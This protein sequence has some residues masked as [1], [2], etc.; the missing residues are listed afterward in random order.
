MIISADEIK[1]SFPEYSPERVEELHA[2]SAKQADKEFDTSLKVSLFKTVALMSGGTASG[3]TEFLVTHLE[4][5]P[6][7]VLDGTLPTPEGAKIKIKKILKARKVPVIYSVIP[8]DLVR[9]FVAFLHRDRKFSES[10]FYRTHSGSRK[11]LLWIAENYPEVELN[12]V[13][14]SYTEDQRLRFKK[15]EFVGPEEFLE[16]LRKIQMTETDIIK[17]VNRELIG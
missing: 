12:L 10:H 4:K 14:S 7:I 5:E 16:Y 2:K 8:D 3:K 11:T 6:F 9:A 13:E 1:K 17:A 15:L